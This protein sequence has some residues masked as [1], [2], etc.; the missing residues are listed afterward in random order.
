MRAPTARGRRSWRVPGGMRKRYPTGSSPWCSSSS[1]AAPWRSTRPRRRPSTWVRPGSTRR[2][3]RRSRSSWRASIATCSAE[4]PAMRAGIASLGPRR[5]SWGD[6]SHQR[7][8]A[9][10]ALL[11]VAVTVAVLAGGGRSPSRESAFERRTSAFL[12]GPRGSKASYDVLA[13]LGVP[14]ERRRRPLFGLTREGARRPG[15][16]VVLD[17]PLDLQAA[18]IAEVVRYVRGGGAVLAAGDG[19]GIA[20]CA[21]WVPARAGRGLRDSLPVVPRGPEPRLPAVATVLKPVEREDIPPPDASCPLLVASGA[22]TLLAGRDARPVVLRLRYPGGGQ[23]TLAADPGYFRNIVW[24]QTGVAAFAVPLFLAG[25]R[26]AIVWDEVH[27]RFGRGGSLTAG[28]PP[29]LVGAPAGWAIPQLAAGLLGAPALAAGGVGAARP[30]VDRRPP[31]PPGHPGGPAGRPGGGGGV[32]TGAGAADP[33]N[34]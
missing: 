20:P 1:A 6:M 13:R 26:G 24:R 29:R 23:V 32:G 4:F 9:L 33:E 22:D 15:L 16:L 25:R 11:A 31:P 7:E 14:V 30:G 2:V 10:A 34:T 21:G 3:A 27:Q 19:G 12:A 17:P 5:T 18:E 8:L 28:T